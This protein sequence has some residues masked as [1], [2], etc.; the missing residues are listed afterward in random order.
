MQN[1]GVKTSRDPVILYPKRGRA[2]APLAVSLLFVVSGLWLARDPAEYD[3]VLGYADAIFGGLGSAISIIMLLPGN[4]FL[5]LDDVG[6]TYGLLFRKKF[7]RWAEVSSFTSVNLG[8]SRPNMSVGWQLLPAYKSTARK[9]NRAILG[10][11]EALPH[12]YGD[13]DSLELAQLM[14]KWAEDAQDGNTQ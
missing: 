10:C 12:T 3:R 1:N 7:R 2:I 11:D 9:I 8:V 14:N 6:F 13:K 4:S 5:K